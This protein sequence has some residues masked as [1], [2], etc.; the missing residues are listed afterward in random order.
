MEPQEFVESHQLEAL[1]RVRRRR[2]LSS[3]LEIRR[4]SGFVN[5]LVVEDDSLDVSTRVD[6]DPSAHALCFIEMHAKGS[7]TRICQRCL[8]PMRVEIDLKFNWQMMR[9]V[10][11][12]IRLAPGHEP[13]AAGD[14][15]GVFELFVQ[16]IMLYLPDIPLHEAQ[17]CSPRASLLM[18]N[19]ALQIE[20]VESIKPDH[21]AALATLTKGRSSG[22]N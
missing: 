6:P 10:V 9:A 17:K 5:N 20:P 15:P 16:E 8:E 4:L 2:C 14:Y 1:T 7:I 18:D 3:R 22:E 21:F 13:L 19:I 12:G 11:P